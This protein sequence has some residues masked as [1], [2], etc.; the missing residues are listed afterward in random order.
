MTIDGLDL[1]LRAGAPLLFLFLAAIIWRDGKGEVAARLF[2]PLSLC[3]SA[4]VINNSDGPAILS[5]RLETLSNLLAGW[6][7]P[8][9]WWFCLATFDRS[10]RL[11]GP[12]AATGA[13]WMILAATN[14]G[15]LGPVVGPFDPRASIM[16]GLATVGHLIWRLLA[17]RHDDLVDR[18]RRLRPVVAL[19]LAAQLLLDLL[20]DLLLG[21]GWRPHWFALVQNASLVLFAAW[22]GWLALQ[23]DI[24]TLFYGR[25]LLDPP[26]PVPHPVTTNPR[27]AAKVRSLIDD[28]RIFL[29]PNLT[30]TQFASRTGSS[31]MV[32]R[33]HI[34]RE[35]GFDNFRVFL[36][37][38]RIKEACRRL[39]DPARRADKIIAIAFD[40]GFASLASFNRTF[41]GSTG[42]T[43]S[44]YRRDSHPTTFEERMPSI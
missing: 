18:R 20:V 11:R 38:Q 39:A 29:D 2:A 25:C 32:V 14:R 37:A 8:F 13:T 21:T 19:L 44:D 6:T 24:A 26:A 9:L 42:Q 36:N 33:R 27:L 35:L 5:G 23:S 3:L 43:P 1:L 17:D 12:V 16:L 22:L 28:D 40:C 4:F 34:N 31:E 30:F 7:V 15:W 10:F 41:L